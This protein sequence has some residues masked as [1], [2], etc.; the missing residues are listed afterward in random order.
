MVDVSKN[1]G[2]GLVAER[3]VRQEEEALAAAEV[4]RKHLLRGEVREE[5]G[6]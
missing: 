6:T 5:T 3:Y 4:L 1:A 2:R